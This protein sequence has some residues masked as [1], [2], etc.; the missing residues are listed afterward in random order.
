MAPCCS[1]RRHLDEIKCHDDND[2]SFFG[3]DDNDDKM[4]MMRWQRAYASCDSARKHASSA[5]HHARAAQVNIKIQ[6]TLCATMLECL[7]FVQNGSRDEHKLQQTKLVYKNVDN[8][9]ETL[10]IQAI[11]CGD[12]M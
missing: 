12:A 6:L 8:A 11:Y 1:P 10:D 3:H 7:L 2:D 4:M 5:L 9:P